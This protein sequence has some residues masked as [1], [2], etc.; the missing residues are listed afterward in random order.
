MQQATGEQEL[1]YTWDDERAPQDSVLI[2]GNGFD[3]ECG[4][5]TTYGDFLAFVNFA[6]YTYDELRAHGH[7][8]PATGLFDPELEGD[9][10]LAAHPDWY[11]G[12]MEE[13][14][15]LLWPVI[16]EIM[17]T[18]G[19]RLNRWVSFFDNFWYKHFMRTSLGK[20]WVDFEADIARV[21]RTI[22]ESMV[23]LRRSRAYMDDHL[24][25]PYPYY[26]ARVLDGLLDG[27]DYHDMEV[28]GNTVYRS[29]D[30][31]Y[32]EVASKLLADLRELSD[33]LEVYLLHYVERAEARETPTITRLLDRVVACAEGGAHAITFNY[34]TTLERL[35]AARGV[36]I[37]ICY[38][39]GRLAD[40]GRRHIVLGMDEY[41]PP[42]SIKNYLGFAAFRKYNQR[43]MLKTDSAYLYWEDEL[44]ARADHRHEVIFFG[45]SMGTSDYDTLR[46]FM[47]LPNSRALVLY[48]DEEAFSERLTNI[49]GM[50]GMDYVVGRIG[51][52]RHTLEFLAQEELS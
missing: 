33:A 18:W 28:A 25:C 37:P 7:V 44:R 49:T 31:T 42:E 15:E 38:V 36:D 19:T 41:L 23:D 46:R 6:H 39:H 17:P 5:P 27:V 34:T 52:E 22:E 45:H 2:I 43:I 51:G 24:G 21:I 29:Y 48:F 13:L 16:E 8:D 3:L 4:L 1:F 32:R 50:M 20:G 47:T 14:G 9:G 35:L 40:D 12:R 11:R 30:V 10:Y 26:P